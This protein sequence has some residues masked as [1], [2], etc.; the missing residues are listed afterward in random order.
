MSKSRRPAVGPSRPATGPKAAGAGPDPIAI[1]L[2]HLFA[3]VAE[4]PIP[5]EFLELLSR[6]DGG[7]Q[8]KPAEPPIAGGKDGSGAS[9][10]A[11]GDTFESDT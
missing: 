11:G 7:G 1:G 9:G 8:A 6:I 4:E 3:S 10:R 5:D 2:Q